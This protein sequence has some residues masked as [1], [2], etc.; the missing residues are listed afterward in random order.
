MLEIRRA[1][2]EDADGVRT[3][4]GHMTDSLRRFYKPT[5]DAYAR[6]ARTQ[7]RRTRLVTV[8]AGLVVGTLEYLK[9]GDVLRVIG[10]AV[11]ER[12]R[13]R[14]IARALVEHLASMG[15]DM[16]CRALSLSTVTATGNV[17]IFRALGFDVVSV[18]PAEFCISQTG[19]SLQEAFLERLT[20]TLHAT[21]SPVPL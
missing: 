17:P 14:G 8:D 3:V 10:L 9:E 5:D 12:H 7:S 4:L 21:A 6:R 13:R 1:V 15:A 18:G 19:E 20:P 16:G 2:A 11:H